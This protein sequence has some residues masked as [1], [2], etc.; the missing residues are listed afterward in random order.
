M[1]EHWG[2]GY[3]TEA[4]T[5][6]MDYCFHNLE[7]KRLCAE[8]DNKNERSKKLIEKLG[9]ELIAVLP[10][11]DFGGTVADVAYYTRTK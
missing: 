5:A 8:I 7:L 11:A 9:F 3:A 6:I 1:K 2:N 10:E 4:V